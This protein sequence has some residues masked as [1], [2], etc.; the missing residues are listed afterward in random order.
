MSVYAI[1]DTTTFLV[2]NVVVWDGGEAWTAPSGCTAV[3]SGVAGIGWSY[4]NGEFIA[5]P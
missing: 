4:T 2:V 3:E 1:V 5:P